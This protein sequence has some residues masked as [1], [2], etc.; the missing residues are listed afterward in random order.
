MFSHTRRSNACAITCVQPANRSRPHPIARLP[1]TTHAGQRK[2]AS[3]SCRLMHLVAPQQRAS[4]T[5]PAAAST[6][7][8][9]HE[10][11]RAHSP[12]ARP[13][14]ELGSWGILGRLLRQSRAQRV[15]LRCR[16]GCTDTPRHA[17]RL[18]EAKELHSARASRSITRRTVLCGLLSF[19]W[20]TGA[21]TE[22]YGG[23]HCM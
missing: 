21:S 20:A 12:C 17:H 19:G 3:Q 1:A 16:L 15:V 13:G 8:C 6:T 9:R 22:T 10:P 11:S 7:R 2:R 4:D 5:H 14:A 23:G 18:V